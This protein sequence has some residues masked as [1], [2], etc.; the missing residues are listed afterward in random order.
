MTPRINLDGKRF[1]SVAT[2]PNGEVSAATLFTYHQD[3][4]IVWAEYSGGAVRWGN[5]LARMDEDGCLEMRY[6]HINTSGE[7]MTGTCASTPEITEDGRIRFHE[8]WRWTSGDG[9]SGTSVVEE[10]R[11][12]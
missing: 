4:S 3:G 8:A 2:T 10:V 5:L 11:A 9:S 12:E 6:Q 1:R 7:F